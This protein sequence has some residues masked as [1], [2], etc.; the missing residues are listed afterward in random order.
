MIELQLEDRNKRMKKLG[1]MCKNAPTL[2]I[3]DIG[4][5][6]SLN[7]ITSSWNRFIKQNELKPISLKGLRTSFATYLAYNGV[8]P[9]VVQAL[10]GHSS[11]RTTMQFYEFAYDNYATSIINTTNLIGKDIK[12]N[13][14]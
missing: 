8:P 2:F 9:K 5:Y 10:L 11:E 7:S 13:K 1:D 12:I 14:K 6:I 3:D 4:D